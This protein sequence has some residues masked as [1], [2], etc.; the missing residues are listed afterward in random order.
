GSGFYPL[1][2]TPGTP[3]VTSYSAHT[4]RGAVVT[5]PEHD[6]VYGTGLSGAV[7]IS[8]NKILG[9]KTNSKGSGIDLFPATSGTLLTLDV[10][11]NTI[12]DQAQF[13][14]SL[15][16]KSSAHVD[17]IIAHN[18][19][20][21]R[22]V[23]GSGSENGGGMNIVAE[24]KSD[25]TTVEISENTVLS[26]NHEGMGMWL[27]V[28]EE[29]GNPGAVLN[30][31]VL[32]NT[33][34]MIDQDSDEGMYAEPRNGETLCLHAKGNTI[35]AAGVEGPATFNADAMILAPQLT[36]TFKVQGLKEGAAGTNAE[37]EELLEKENSLSAPP[38]GLPVLIEAHK[39]FSP[40]TCPVP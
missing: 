29:S 22:T 4:V 31:T 25:T 34:E 35:K 21:E 28:N 33:I 19:I 6:G 16:S 15:I 23:E 24:G 37:V 9:N 3:V 14:I 38:G 26:I 40:G 2:Q 39:A 8:S 18:T 27:V 10:A 20:G 12:A 17:G 5:A 11:N 30:A 13:G 1:A 7:T 36:S 32:N